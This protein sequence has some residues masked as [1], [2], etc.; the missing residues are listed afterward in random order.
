M[1]INDKSVL[2]IK[3]FK[4]VFNISLNTKYTFIFILLI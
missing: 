2:E 4:I 3:E 1:L